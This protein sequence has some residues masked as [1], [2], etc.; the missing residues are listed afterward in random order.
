MKPSLEPHQLLLSSKY[1]ALHL[2]PPRSPRRTFSR[3]FFPS[4][5]SF[6]IYTPLQ[7]KVFPCQ[8]SR[9]FTFSSLTDFSSPSFRA[10]FSRHSPPS[11]RHCPLGPWGQSGGVDAPADW[12]WG[13]PQ[14]EPFVRLRAPPPGGD[15]APQRARSQ[16]A[17]FL[18][19]QR[20]VEELKRGC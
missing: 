3:N 8:R 19:S 4:T 12:R 2:A 20:R 15:S 11:H 1:F 5:P 9:C 10:F 16:T 18:P 7:P 13:V 6:F 14:P 17:A